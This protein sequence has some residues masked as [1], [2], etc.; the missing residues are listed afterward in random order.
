MSRARQNRRLARSFASRLGA[1][2]GALAVEDFAQTA[3]TEEIDDYAVDGC[4]ASAEDLRATVS[5]SWD[6]PAIGA[7]AAQ[8]DGCPKGFEAAYYAAYEAAA[9][10]AVETMAAALESEAA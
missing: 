5:G 3:G 2:A 6:G 8:I 9:V 7:G 4:A 1:A 10:R